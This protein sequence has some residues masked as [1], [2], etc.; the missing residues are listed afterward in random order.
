MCER[1]SRV[2]WYPLSR[3]DTSPQEGLLQMVENRSEREFGG[4]GLSRPIMTSACFRVGMPSN[5]G[6]S[7][8]GGSGQMN[9]KL[10]RSVLRGFTVSM[11]LQ[12][13]H[14]QAC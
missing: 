2:I 3:C 12:E 10:V 8:G 1:E 5:Q 7:C 13:E 11:D 4:K 6:Q 14:L 9:F